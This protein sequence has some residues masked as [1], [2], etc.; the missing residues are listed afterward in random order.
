MKKKIDINCD[1]GESLD[2]LHSGH[3]EALMTFIT[4]VNIACG[5]HAGNEEIMLKTVENAQKYKL[6]IGAHPSFDDKENFGRNE[7]DLDFE[8]IKELILKQLNILDKVLK[9]KDLKMHHVKPHGALYNMSAKKSEY[10]RAIAEAVF[11]FNNELILFGLSGSLSISEAKKIGLKTYDECFSDRSYMSNGSLSPRS[12][13]NAL[14]VDVEEVKKQTRS[15]V[16]GS[17]FSTLDGNFIKI[18]CDTICIHSDTPNALVF[19]KAIY[20][21]AK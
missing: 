14:K 9:A 2:F 3:D 19:A 10:A 5:F 11:E 6:N 17:A 15:L 13:E 8:E 4:S 1:M 18:N 7:M 12:L 16:D 20:D 21:I